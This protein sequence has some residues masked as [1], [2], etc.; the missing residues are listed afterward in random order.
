M[1]IGVAGPSGVKRKQTGEKIL[2]IPLVD[3]MASD[4]KKKT[5]SRK[6]AANDA[7]L[8]TK[9]KNQRN[10]QCVEN[11]YG[12]ILPSLEVSFPIHNFL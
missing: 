4:K 12:D 9:K 2:S 1:E 5:Y 8:K 11:Q 10:I 6:R 7:V 3:I